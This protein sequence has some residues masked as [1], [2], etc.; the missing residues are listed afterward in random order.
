MESLL[1]RTFPALIKP[2]QKKN[3]YYYTW[4]NTE[5]MQIFLSLFF[6]LSLFTSSF[7]FA[8]SSSITVS[9]SSSIH[10]YHTRLWPLLFNFVQFGWLFLS[11]NQLDGWVFLK[12]PLQPR[13]KSIFS[14]F[15]LLAVLL[16]IVFGA[17]QR[18]LITAF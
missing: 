10:K 8:T 16:A 9:L 12:F 15:G 6:F 5:Q 13:N 2:P 7:P 11:S 14:R 1:P 3:Y 4:A 18:G 17:R